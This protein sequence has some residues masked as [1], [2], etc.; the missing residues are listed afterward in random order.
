MQDLAR[1]TKELPRGANI[2]HT[3]RATPAGPANMVGVCFL[4]QMLTAESLNCLLRTSSPRLLDWFPCC[5]TAVHLLLSLLSMLRVCL[6]DA[7][8]CVVLQ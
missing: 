1:V 8:A 5:S 3:P 2:V 6:A 4:S 7:A